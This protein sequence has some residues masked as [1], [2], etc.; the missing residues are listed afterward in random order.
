MKQPLAMR[1]SHAPSLALSVTLVAALATSTHA[2]A[3]AAQ[4]HIE[5]ATELHKEGKY[6]EA[7]AELEMAYALDQQPNLIYAIAQVHVK[8]GRCPEAITFYEEF[9]A[10][11]PDAGPAGA[12]REAIDV[13]K[14]AAPPTVAP[15]PIPTAVDPAP[16][17]P[18][19]PTAPGLT[20]LYKDPIGGALVGAGLITGVVAAVLYSGARSRLDDAETAATYQI[21]EALVDA[22]AR[23]RTY[24]AIAGAGAFALVGAG[25]VHMFVRDRGTTERAVAITPSTTGA[26]VTWSGSF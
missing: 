26:F 9:L 23:R 10:T 14:A 11:K 6:V 17:P 19:A 4:P 15:D 5:R 22:A 8:L 13:C 3:P 12:A 18:I 2:D 20:P 1:R 24:A 21:S 25:V 16:P 7:L